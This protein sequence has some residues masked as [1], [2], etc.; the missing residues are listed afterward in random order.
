MKNLVFFILMLFIFAPVFSI[1]FESFGE[2]NY[3]KYVLTKDTDILYV[4]SSKLNPET[5]A[6]LFSILNDEE[7]EI[8]PV[9]NDTF[10]KFENSAFLNKSTYCAELNSNLTYRLLYDGFE[11]F[12]Y[13]VYYYDKINEE[14]CKGDFI[15]GNKVSSYE[16]ILSEIDYGNYSFYDVIPVFGSS[17]FDLE[18]LKLIKEFESDLKIDIAEYYDEE[19]YYYFSK[20][21]HN[22]L[23]IVS[24][25][26]LEENDASF[27]YF[28]KDK[29]DGHGFSSLINKSEGIQ[30]DYWTYGFIILVV[31]KI[32]RQFTKK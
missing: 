1:N 13:P 6:E 31:F 17:F 29:S 16:I 14:L 19:Y 18:E 25:T 20:N 15:T 26:M 11:S 4:Y 32:I 23:A 28:I 9:N 21:S 10:F 24:E 3:V 7:Y 8:Y 2:K 27:E 22:L 12:F 30:L 5:M